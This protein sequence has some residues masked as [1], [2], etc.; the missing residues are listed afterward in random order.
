MAK[1]ETTLNLIAVDLEHAADHL[2]HPKTTVC[3]HYE[4]VFVAK[5][6][7]LL[8]RKNKLASL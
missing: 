8:A 4:V 1:G 3:G 6:L 5:S 7:S 2:M